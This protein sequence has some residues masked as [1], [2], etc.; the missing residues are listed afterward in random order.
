MFRS[1][2]LGEIV[3]RG[4]LDRNQTMLGKMEAVRFELFRIESIYPKIP[5]GFMVGPDDQKGIGQMA[6]EMLD[7]GRRIREEN[8][9]NSSR[10]NNRL[11]RRCRG[12]VVVCGGKKGRRN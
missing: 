5:T 1:V 12:C 2:S 11:V 8:T 4:Y 6:C 9:R 7:R 10:A 3:T